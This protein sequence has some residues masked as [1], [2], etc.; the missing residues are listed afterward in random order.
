MARL[1]A[2]FWEFDRGEFAKHCCTMTY[3]LVTH[4]IPYLV[5]G[6]G[7]N[8][9]AWYKSV[10][11]G[12][13]RVWTILLSPEKEGICT[14]GLPQTLN[15]SIQVQKCNVIL[16]NLF[17]LVNLL[18]I[19]CWHAFI[20]LL[21]CIGSAFN[22]K[23]MMQCPNCRKVERGQWLYASGPNHNHSSSDDFDWMGDDIY[24]VTFA[25][26]VL[27]Y[28]NFFAFLCVILFLH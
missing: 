11:K 4:I 12:S 20:A 26:L 27:N 6:M 28:S 15:C 17:H 3:F 14:F 22:A 13:C 7:M 8:S 19:Y 21:D 16:K 23:G 18:L 2:W 9:M 24:D 5:H 10:K 1:S 25:E